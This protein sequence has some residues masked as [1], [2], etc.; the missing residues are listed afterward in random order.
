MARLRGGS[1]HFFQQQTWFVW[2]TLCAHGKLVWDSTCWVAARGM[3]AARALPTFRQSRKSF[4]PLKLRNISQLSGV[5]SVM[6]H[7]A[8]QENSMT[9]SHCEGGTVQLCP[10]EDT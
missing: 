10:P 5:S 4:M 3:V 6:F 9:W 1:W 2:L 8:L 7:R